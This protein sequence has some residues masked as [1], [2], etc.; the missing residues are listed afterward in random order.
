LEAVF[1]VGVD[2]TVQ[3]ANVKKR[4]LAHG[5]PGKDVVFLKNTT[6]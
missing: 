5:L 1:A 2:P 4:D 6:G 3:A